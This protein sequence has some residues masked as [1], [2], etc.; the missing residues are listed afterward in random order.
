M[1]GDGRYRADLGETSLPEVLEVVGARGGTGV[2]EV[3]RAGMVKRVYLEDAYVVH[4]SSSD[5]I[6]R[7]SEHIRRA[8]LIDEERIDAIDQRRS[9]S[10]KRLGVLLIEQDLL[11]PQEVYQAICGQIEDIVRS[12]FA[13]DS[14]AAVFTPGQVR[15]EE[16][17][18]VRLPLRRVIF[19]GLKRTLGRDADAESGERRDTALEPSFRYEDLIDI[20]LDRAEMELLEAVDGRTSWSELCA[21]G[22]L[23][24]DECARRLYAFE[25]LS[26]VRPVE[27]VATDGTGE[28]SSEA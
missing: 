23:S 11:S 9:N 17:V 7:L 28:T 6:D 26:L 16:M 5:P 13:W 20:G 10:S 18:Q 21:S 2:L 25:V 4:A 14:G 15:L 12:L 1:T 24:P 27:P 3:T 8:G 22:I 19:E